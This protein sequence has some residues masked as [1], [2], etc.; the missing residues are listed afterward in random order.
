MK[1]KGIVIQGA[2]IPPQIKGRTDTTGPWGKNE[3]I[4][5]EIKE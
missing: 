3:A 2:G 1:R 5:G 4:V